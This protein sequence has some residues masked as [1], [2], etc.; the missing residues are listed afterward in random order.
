MG[1]VISDRSVTL[2]L[3]VLTLKQK[4]PVLSTMNLVDIE[5]MAGQYP[6]IKRSGGYQD[7]CAA[8]DSVGMQVDMTA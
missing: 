6:E 5:C 7:W 8:S 2:C 1:R 4:R 3:C